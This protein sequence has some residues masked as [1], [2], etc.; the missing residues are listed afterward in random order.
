MSRETTVTELA[1][2]FEV[3]RQTI[4]NWR[5][6]GCPIERGKDAIAVWVKENRPS[7]SPT[8][9]RLLMA[10]IRKLE[11]EAD[12]TELENRVARGELVKRDAVERWLSQFCSATRAIIESWPDTVVTEIP[13]THR[14]IV[15]EILSENCRLLLVTL[16]DMPE[17]L[18]ADE[19]VKGDA[20]PA[21]VEE[22]TP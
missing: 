12:R 13:G 9:E 5:D 20:A 4:Y 2:I 3:S 14:A 19:S 17:E 15:Y 6:A 1:E 21:A 8:Q 16:A 10:R 22:S 11:A 7:E 18:W